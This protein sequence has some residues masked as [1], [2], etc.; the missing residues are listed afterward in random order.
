MVQHRQ[1]APVLTRLASLTRPHIAFQAAL[2]TLLGAYLASGFAALATPAVL[3]AGLV[4]ALV[5]AYGFVIN[6]YADF[7]LD[8]ATKPTRPLPSG[9]FTPAAALQ[10]AG[11]LAGAAIVLALWLPALL[12]AMAVVNVALATAYAL[13]LKRTVLLGN[14]A[15]ALLNSSIVLFG[16]LAAGT[17]SDLVWVVAAVSLLYTLAQ[18]LLYTVDDFAGDAAAGIVTTAI[19][20]GTGTTLWLV[21]LLL[22]LTLVSACV[23]WLLGGAPIWYLAALGICTVAPVVGVIFRLLG[24]GSAE[25]IS[26]ACGWVRLTRLTSLLPLLLLHFQRT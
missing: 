4:V 25:A 14:V 12:L 1:S 5:V 16:A 20:F 6:D 2:Y 22:L 11:V 7:E 19:Y 9:L 3:L 24:R 10:I 18:E 21:R 13:L 15:M 23:P 26:Q 17:L 8:S